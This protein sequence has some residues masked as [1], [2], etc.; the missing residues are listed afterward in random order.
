MKNFPL[1]RI[2]PYVKPHAPYLVFSLLFSV[3]STACA[4]VIPVIIGKTIDLFL[5][6]GVAFKKV[7]LNLGLIAGLAV[8]SA[9]AQLLNGLVNN[10][11]AFLT[12]R[13]LRNDVMA[14]FG[15]IPLRYFDAKPSGE[16]IGN[17]LS[18]AEAVSDGFLL[19]VTQIFSGAVTIVGTLI[20]MLIYSP[21]IALA[22]VV[23]TPLSVFIARFI[24]KKSREKFTEQ[25]KIRAEQTTFVEETV[26]NHKTVK[27][28]LM[29]EKYADKYAGINERLRKATESAV[30]FSSLT[31]PTTRFVNSLVYAA[32]AL[33]GGLTC[34]GVI[35][36]F[37]LSAGMLSGLLYYA[38]QFA[39]PFNEISGVIAE[40]QASVVGA[41]RI[42][43]LLDEKEE[44][45]EK[46]ET[47]LP[48]GEVAFKGVAFSYDPSRPFIEGM[49]FTVQPGEHVAIVGP[50]GCGKTTLINL[51]MRF[52][53][54]DAGAIEVDGKDVRSVTRAS[55]RTSFGMVLQE[56]WIRNATVR[57]NLTLG[58]DIPEEEMIKA[59][60]LCKSDDFIRALPYGYDTVIDEDSLSQGQKQLLCITRVMLSKGQML[61]LDEA[62]SAV[63]VR[64][65]AAINAAFDALMKGKTSFIVAHRLTT[66]R[67][68]DLILVMKDGKVIEQG[69]H[70][71]LM[72]QGGF[73]KELYVANAAE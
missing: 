48:V 8:A 55:L 12:V 19:G 66:I 34:A 5:V 10:R 20:M 24:A 46:E 25:A 16:I 56:S 6:G 7:Y 1:K 2:F 68:A 61:I 23:I 45:A 39:K 65:E 62:T 69:S 36:A 11:L 21:L 18:D 41:K 28:Y 9:L 42:F 38:G 35:T 58:N 13:D 70:E 49:N 40:L 57:E 71:E 27:A 64:T 63:D 14:K 53:D 22:V 47:L 37:S 33:I 30:F 15:K 54:V 26:S 50:T 3:F 72:E 29:E 44:S 60:V 73:Y 51:L 59:A 17:M 31:N 4:L 67:H 43:S 52:Y 32:V